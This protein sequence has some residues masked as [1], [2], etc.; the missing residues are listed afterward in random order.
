MNLVFTLLALFAPAALFIL[1]ALGAGTP[2]ERFVFFMGSGALVVLAFGLVGYHRT[3]NPPLAQT[4]FM[5]SM[6][7]L[8]WLLLLLPD[9]TNRYAT[10][11]RQ[12][13]E[14]GFALLAVGVLTYHWLVRSGAW[15][16]RQARLISMKI[17]KKTDWPS[18][19]VAIRESPLVRQFREALAFDANPALE[20]MT[21][22]QPEVRLAA[23]S[24]LEYRPNW[25]LGQVEAVLNHLQNE[26]VPA[27]RLAAINAV[28]NV[29]DR[30]ATELLAEA[31]DDSDPRV[32]QAASDALFWDKERRWDWL[33]MGVRSA[34][35][36]PKL[37]DCGSMIR[38]GQQLPEEGVANLSAWAAERGIVSVRAAQTLAVH[39]VRSLQEK[40]EQ[41]RPE[42]LKT[43]Q[44]PQAP[45][46]LRIQFARL[47][48]KFD[49]IDATNLEKLLDGAN[50]APLR[51][52]AAELL[53][54]RVWNSAAVAALRDIAKLPNRELGLDTARIV[55][56]CLNVDMGLVPG[57]P[58]PPANS[59]KAAEI[60]RRL[61]LWAS[62]AESESAL[63][64]G[65][66]QVNLGR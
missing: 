30:R 16:F 20:L 4:V 29:E 18:D 11:Y 51:Q 12:I 48:A 34:L 54:G 5:T 37:H 13:L 39:Y 27:V 57:Q 31:L 40:P 15:L 55:Q 8:F 43:V 14:A 64:T 10:G 9:S 28:A 22:R 21:H 19:P 58:P 50:P 3:L 38:E 17:A 6:A 52:L 36:D 33:R 56:G 35:A 25:R 49:K 66:Q 45:P 7:A 32:R 63:D 62:K 23:L 65:F 41:T 2:E 26:N 60:I 1:G 46:L 47:L 61:A 24:A 53:L 42:L 59:P 44:D